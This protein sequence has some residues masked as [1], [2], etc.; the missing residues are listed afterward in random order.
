[1][2]SVLSMCPGL[3]RHAVSSKLDRTSPS[4]QTESL[5]DGDDHGYDWRG[6]GLGARSD[7]GGGGSF[8]GGI[9]ALTERTLREHAAAAAAAGT[10]AGGR[11]EQLHGK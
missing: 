9:V 7:V 5:V 11:L 10:G 4:S 8:K 1:M 3:E 6:V 2:I